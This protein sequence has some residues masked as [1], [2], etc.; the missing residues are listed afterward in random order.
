MEAFTACLE[1]IALE[2]LDGC[3]IVHLWD[4]L[5]Q[6]TPTFPLALDDLS[7]EFLWRGIVESLDVEFFVL[8]HPLPHIF[9]GKEEDKSSATPFPHLIEEINALGIDVDVKCNT[10]CLVNDEENGICGS[11]PEYK[12]RQNVTDDVRDSNS[13]KCVIPLKQAYDR[14]SDRLVIVASQKERSKFLFDSKLDSN[15][16]LSE[17]AYFIVE[18]IGQARHRGRLQSLISHVDPRTC[19]YHLKKLVVSGVITKQYLLV[20][21]HV[22]QVSFTNVLRLKRFDVPRLSKLMHMGEKIT[23]IL[24]KQPGKK[25]DLVNL[26]DLF[27]V[28]ETSARSF[29][30]TKRLLEK[31]GYI[32][33]LQEKRPAI[34]KKKVRASKNVPDPDINSSPSKLK[35]CLCV[36]LIKPFN[37]S[38]SDDEDEEYKNKGAPCYVYEKSLMNQVYD[39]VEK[40]G[41]DGATLKM[42]END[43]A[44]TNAESNKM[45][46][47]LEKDGHLKGI[48][49]YAEKRNVKRFV[50]KP[51]VQKSILSTRIRKEEEKFKAIK[52]SLSSPQASSEVESGGVAQISGS[53]CLSPT[54]STQSIDTNAS[55]D[56]SEK[57]GKTYRSLKRKNTVLEFLKKHKVCEGVFPILKVVCD[58]EAA[59]GFKTKPDHKVIKRVI[60][61]LERDGLLRSFKTILNTEVISKPVEFYIDSSINDQDPKVKKAISDAQLKLES[62]NQDLQSQFQPKDAKIKAVKETIPK[63]RVNKSL[64]CKFGY[65]AKFPRMRVLHQYF[66]QITHGAHGNLRKSGASSSAASPLEPS[67]NG[68]NAD[69]ADASYDCGWEDTVESTPLLEYGPGWLKLDDALQVMPLSIYCNALGITT[70]TSIII[71]S[72]RGYYHREESEIFV[73]LRQASLYSH[74]VG[75]TTE[76]PGLEEMY[77]N[78]KAR[79][80][81][82]KD[83]PRR[84]IVSLT[85]ENNCKEAFCMTIA[86]L[87]AMG[88]LTA[89]RPFPSERYQTLVH[90]SAGA[91]LVDTQSSLPG[92]LFVKEPKDFPFP[93]KKYIFDSLAAVTTYWNDFKY[94]SLNTPLGE[95][96][97]IGC[98]AKCW[99]DTPWRLKS[100]S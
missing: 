38:D 69:G 27:K 61:E 78:P 33:M 14:W 71:L 89:R 23:D 19:F 26:R 56:L 29:K 80:T 44:M 96:A 11:C 10:Y 100:A 2:G 62:A 46:Q 16:F 90:V 95:S 74:V 50:A 82:L 40:Y 5:K 34:V 31:G 36:Q 35:D 73:S 99:G 17:V 49:V 60:N 51:Y 93:Q 48:T 25:M 20:T 79:H 85:R 32:K 67:W 59:E 8:E 42:V 52:E 9:G 37:V 81:L 66:W 77:N 64:R 72:C 6:R 88:L 22:G 39:C 18:H 75:I 70:E 55:D 92:S 1:E 53:R 58:I 83:L 3:P 28:N 57:R 13:K 76:I 7:K 54:P 4:L 97:I 15:V 98:T 47:I 87:L 45:L 94:I 65:L 21:S 43:L 91:I 68:G 24:S 12:T 41:P 63:S 84:M 86:T 30:R